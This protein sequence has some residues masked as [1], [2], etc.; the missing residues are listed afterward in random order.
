MWEFIRDD[1]IA[2]LRQNVHTRRL[3]ITGI[4]LGGGLAALSFVDILASKEFENV[5]VI[6]F[7]APRVGNK[8]W[9]KWFDSVTDSTRIYIRR[10]PIAFLPRCLTPICN[11]RQTGN[12][13]VCYPGKNECRCKSK[14]VE[15]ELEMDNAIETIIQEVNEHKDEIAEGEFGG[16]LDHIFGYKKIKDYSLVC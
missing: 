14:S 12:P 16:I 9:A 7:G 3:V 4:S 11:Y 8:K 2:G 6:T 15:D 10:D 1:V 5:E 13:I